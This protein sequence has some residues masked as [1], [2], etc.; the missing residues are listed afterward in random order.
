MLTTT[1]FITL[2]LAALF[3]ALMRMSALQSSSSFHLLSFGLSYLPALFLFLIPG[4]FSLGITGPFRN[5]GE[6]LKMNQPD[7]NQISLLRFR[8][9]SHLTKIQF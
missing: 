6:D 4:L 1:S 8:R 9:F 5:Q 7:E 2:R 3:P